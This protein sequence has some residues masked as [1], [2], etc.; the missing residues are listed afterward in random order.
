[1]KPGDLVVYSPKG[2]ETQPVP[3]SLLLLV[4]HP[5]NIHAKFSGCFGVRDV[6]LVLEFPVDDLYKRIWVRILCSGGI[7][8]V[9]RREISV[10][11]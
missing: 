2:T 11:P 7:G 8:W 1:V 9:I 5:D 10:I 6:G 4:T 3:D